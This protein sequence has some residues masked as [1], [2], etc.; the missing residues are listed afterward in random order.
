[1]KLEEDAAAGKTKA[2]TRLMN[3]ENMKNAIH[4]TNELIS[5]GKEHPKMSKLREI[6]ESE[7]KANKMTQFIIFAQFRDTIAK[8]MEELKEINHAAPIEFIGQ[9]KK[10]GKGLSQKEQMQI[11]NE[12]MM[13]FYNIL[14][15]SQVG[16]EG[17]DVAETGVVIFYEPVPSAVRRVQRSGRTARTQKGK[18]IMLITKGTR[19]EAYHWSGHNK[20]KKMNKILYDMQR[21]GSLEKFRE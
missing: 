16:E 1:M 10:K 4:L 20:E 8:I 7:L 11:L 21:Q 13:G 9:A 17:L 6:I 3:D 15:A 2:V 12:F 18:V 5:Q 19:D 14:I